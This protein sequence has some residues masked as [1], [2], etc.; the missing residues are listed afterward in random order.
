M[1]TGVRNRTH[2]CNK[3]GTE[4][5]TEDYLKMA[6]DMKDGKQPAIQNFGLE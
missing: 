3:D 4:M 2:L 1:P 5:T 6:N